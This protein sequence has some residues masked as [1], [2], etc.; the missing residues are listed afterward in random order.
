MEYRVKV[1]NNNSKLGN[2]IPNIN[3]PA[4]CTCREDAPCRKLCYAQ[5]GRFRYEVVQKRAFEN[6]KAWET[7]PK[8]FEEDVKEQTNLSKFVRWH[9]SGDIPDM[10]YLEMMCRVAMELEGTNYLCFTKKYELVNQFLNS[11]NT[12]PDNLTIVFS[13]WGNWKPENPY[14]LPVAYVKLKG[15]EV[16]IPVD[17]KECPSYCGKCAATNNSCWKLKHGESVCFKQH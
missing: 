15:I 8:Q 16:D 10:A 3:L 6:L 9:S 5:R 11:G 4:G 12:I 14:N 7:D 1:G 13:A 2:Q 17:A